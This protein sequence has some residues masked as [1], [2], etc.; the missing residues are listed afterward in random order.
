MFIFAFVNNT[1]THTF[2]TTPYFPP[3]ATKCFWYL[4]DFLAQ[5]LENLKCKPKAVWLYLTNDQEFA[6]ICHIYCRKYA[7]YFLY[8]IHY[9]LFYRCT[10]S[11]ICVSSKRRAFIT[12]SESACALVRNGRKV[13]DL[14]FSQLCWRRFKSFGLS[15]RFD[16]QVVIDVSEKCAPFNS[17]IQ[18]CKK[19]GQ[20][21]FCGLKA[22]WNVVQN[23]WIWLQCELDF[24]RIQSTRPTDSVR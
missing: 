23:G 5:A 3:Y 14:S 11:V 10:N 19:K 24:L 22:D 4:Q 6:I 1:D 13:R 21:P 16:W 15:Q 2:A 17:F 9:L 18:Q 8:I 7:L 20:W 12:N